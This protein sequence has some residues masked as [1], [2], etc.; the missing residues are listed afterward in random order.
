MVCHNIEYIIYIRNIAKH[1]NIFNTI[2]ILRYQTISVCQLVLNAVTGYVD[3]YPSSPLVCVK[4][5][6][7]K[8]ACSEIH[9]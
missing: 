7:I 1:L 9:I 6:A 4:S 5:I 8:A 2:N 3:R